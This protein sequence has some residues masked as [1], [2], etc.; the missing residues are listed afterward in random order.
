MYAEVVYEDVGASVLGI[1][2]FRRIFGNGTKVEF[3]V[4]RL[5]ALTTIFFELSAVGGGL[6]VGIG[7]LFVGGAEG[8]GVVW[9]H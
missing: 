2:G 9:L 5:E 1:K 4:R 6:G 8:P 3:D 7:R